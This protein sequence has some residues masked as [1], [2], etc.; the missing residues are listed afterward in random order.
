MIV[1]LRFGRLRQ[2]T[3]QVLATAFSMFIE[4]IL[5]EMAEML[6]R[7]GV[8]TDPAHEKFTATTLREFFDLLCTIAKSWSDN[9]F[10]C[11]A[12][13][14]VMMDMKGPAAVYFGSLAV[15]P[16]TLSFETFPRCTTISIF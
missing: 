14:Q 4:M 3:S 16:S 1:N 9:K 5:E 6:A 8:I 10:C 12:V 11:H 2:R 15:R 7:W 13:A